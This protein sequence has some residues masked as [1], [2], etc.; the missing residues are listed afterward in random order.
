[1]SIILKQ[2]FFNSKINTKEL[3]NKIATFTFL[4]FLIIVFLRIRHQA[5]VLTGNFYIQDIYNLK[6]SNLFVKDMKTSH[7]YPLLGVL[8]YKFVPTKIFVALAPFALV[9]VYLLIYF[10]VSKNII[11]WYP[12]T[13]LI[14]IFFPTFLP[15]TIDWLLLPVVYD[16]IKTKHDTPALIIG[17]MMVY[18]HG[19]IPLFYL[20]VL[21]LVMRK[22]MLFVKILLFS[23]P[24]LIP[25]LYFSQGYFLAHSDDYFSYFIYGKYNGSPFL[26]ILRAKQIHMRIAV[27]ASYIFTFIA[28]IFRKEK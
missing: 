17:T 20:L 16:R 28:L 26:Y 11:Y 5:Q 7:A 12:A 22:E 10:L 23:L 21:C 4:V 1:M 13:V 25:L 6:T 2:N 8:I 15:T 24:Q 27:M 18:I 3:I 19:F 9:S 14:P